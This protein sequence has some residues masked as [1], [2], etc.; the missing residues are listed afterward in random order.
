MNLSSII[1]IGKCFALILTMLFVLDA[2]KESPEVLTSHEKRQKDSIYGETDDLE[3]LLRHADSLK[4]KKDFP[5][6]AILEKNIGKMLRDDSQ[7]IEAI[8]HHQNGLQYA[9]LLNDTIEMVKAYNNVGTD[10][11]RIG[12][13][14]DALE[15][16]YAALI[17]CEKF[18]DKKTYDAKKNRVTALN[19]LGNAYL[20]MK[21]LCT[22]DS[23]FREALAD[24]AALNSHLGQAI[25]YANLGAIFE[26]RGRLDSS[27]VYYRK[28][29]EHNR[30]A[31]SELGICLCHISFGH[32]YERSRQW[33]RAILEYRKAYGIMKN[34]SDHWHWLEAIKA[35]ANVNI[36]KGDLEEAKKYVNEAKLVAD[37]INSIE[38]MSEVAMLNY[39]IYEKQGNYL[40]A[41]RY[42]RLAEEM[43]DSIMAAENLTSVKNYQIRYVN[44]KH[45]NEICAIE[46]MH[47]TES[48]LMRTTIIAVTLALVLVATF[49]G[50][51]LYMWNV[52][53]KRYK[54]LR[55]QFTKSME[56]GAEPET[57][58]G[59]EDN[60]FLNKLVNMI[61]VKM[62]AGEISVSSL[63]ESMYISRSQLSRRVLNLTGMNTSDFVLQVRMGK[64]RRMLEDSTTPITEIAC[65]CGFNDPS[66]FT[67]MYKKT[68]N[69]TPSQA[70][71]RS[72]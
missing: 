66:H 58:L 36:M 31:G 59:A 10:F 62:Q 4:K 16:H 1:H 50:I 29:M 38:H 20:T 55:E 33:D 8:R 44:E 32:L 51:L 39:K 14:K 13:L 65:L 35:L 64:A 56:K 47:N 46:E 22:A 19:G 2:C 26:K 34:S 61:Y 37:E 30:K 57:N 11:R 48:K 3:L 7:F 24:E 72:K 71:K 42:Y 17:L 40:E 41:L 63:A 27:W 5:T 43:E 68:Y 52:R 12:A 69:I 49:A 28:S 18:S 67:R 53:S 25:N 15:N 23:L 54:A 45:R 9:T 60:E 21:D 70:R 6:L